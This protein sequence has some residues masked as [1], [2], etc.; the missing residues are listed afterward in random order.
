VDRY[1]A[2]RIE[3]DGRYGQVD[4]QATEAVLQKAK[5]T[6]RLRL[7]FIRGISSRIFCLPNLLGESAPSL[8]SFA[9]S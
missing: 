7:D 9:R 1:P 4:A 6:R 8:R 2:S 5:G 3:I